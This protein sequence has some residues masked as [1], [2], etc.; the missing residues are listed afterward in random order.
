MNTAGAL[1]RIYKP[2]SRSNLR[3]MKDI[4]QCYANNYVAFA[5][6]LGLSL[7]G[8]AVDHQADSMKYAGIIGHCSL[9]MYY[10]CTMIDLK[11]VV[12]PIGPVER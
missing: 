8:G 3:G 10:T 1:T 9:Y 5:S 11:N 7:L 12:I 2:A 6:A 4:T